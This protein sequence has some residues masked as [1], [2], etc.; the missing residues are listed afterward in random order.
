MASVVGVSTPLAFSDQQRMLCRGSDIREPH[1]VLHHMVHM[2]H[3]LANDEGGGPESN[4]PPLLFA[5]ILHILGVFA[6]IYV[7]RVHMLSGRLLLRIWI[8]IS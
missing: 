8:S 1:R 4:K 5:A 6:R 2:P 7:E 3:R